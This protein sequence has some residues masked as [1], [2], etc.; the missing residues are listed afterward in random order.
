M[1]F[2]NRVITHPWG[3][4]ALEPKTT[5]A[6]KLNPRKNE[7]NNKQWSSKSP[8]LRAK[9][10]GNL[11]QTSSLS[12]VGPLSVVFREIKLTNLAA[13][14]GLKIP[15]TFYNSLMNVVEGLHIPSYDS[16]YNLIGLTDNFSSLK[17]FHQALP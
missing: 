5:Y 2:C 8:L 13:C 3:L 6:S 10:V 17:S 11:C 9:N 7:H 15:L 16:E 4:S 14:Y 1:G 12:P